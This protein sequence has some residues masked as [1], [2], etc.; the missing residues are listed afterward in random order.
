VVD[1]REYYQYG[2]DTEVE[3]DKLQELQ[4]QAKEF[5]AKISILL[6]E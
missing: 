4:K 1:L 5:V 3:I 6:E 2:T